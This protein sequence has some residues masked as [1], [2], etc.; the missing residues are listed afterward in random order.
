MTTAL[1][2]IQKELIT[3]NGEAIPGVTITPVTDMKWKA[4]IAG[5]EDSPYEGGLF[6]L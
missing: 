5:P 2:R 4:T 1:K 3:L 6:A